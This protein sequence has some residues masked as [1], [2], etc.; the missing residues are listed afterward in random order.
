L[1]VI[2]S[3]RQNDSLGNDGRRYRKMTTT[4]FI[5]LR[6]ALGDV[7]FEIGKKAVGNGRGRYA[8]GGRPL[9]DEGFCFL[10]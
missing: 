7:W 8:G 2:V 1:D 10:P 4:P 9:V 5:G 3:C 6:K